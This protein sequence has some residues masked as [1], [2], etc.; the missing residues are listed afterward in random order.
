MAVGHDGA[1]WVGYGLAGVV[2]A[3]MPAVEWVH[4]RQLRRVL[5]E[6]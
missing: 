1:S 3:A 4:I 2:A 5:G 6:Y